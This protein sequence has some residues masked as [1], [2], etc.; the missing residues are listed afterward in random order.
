M[1]NMNKVT[2]FIVSL[3]FLIGV[4]SSTMEAD[5]WSAESAIYFKNAFEK[6]KADGKN[7]LLDFHASWCP[8]CRKQKKAL[9]EVLGDQDF[10]RLV[11]FEVN[12]DDET[13]LEK[14]LGVT[15]QS[16]LILFYGPKEISRSVSVTDK[17]GL[18]EFLRKAN[19]K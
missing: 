10:S 15:A 19:N 3:G 6:A 4:T 11:A 7:I 17:E 9:T 13:K 5:S 2:V 18:R 1:K 8:T 16:T 14:H 12:Y